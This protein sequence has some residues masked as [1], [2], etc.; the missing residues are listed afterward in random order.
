MKA[1]NPI[2]LTVSL[3]NPVV[4]IFPRTFRP[5]EELHHLTLPSASL[6]TVLMCYS[7]LYAAEVQ[8]NLVIC[9]RQVDSIPRAPY[10]P[11]MKMVS[12]VRKMTRTRSGIIQER[13]KQQ[14]QLEETFKSYISRT[15]QAQV[16]SALR[17]RLISS[18]T[19]C[20]NGWGLIDR[21]CRDLFEHNV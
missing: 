3:W 21:D 13:R 7:V 10:L 17:V 14:K 20:E 2:Q 12:W 18:I 1:S 8:C 4:S 15:M 6:A 19:F 11:S 16:H 9:I 5:R